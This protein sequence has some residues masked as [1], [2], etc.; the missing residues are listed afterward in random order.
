MK[1]ALISP[2]ESPIK[3]ITGWEEVEP[4][5]IPPTYNP[6]LTQITN[7][8]RVA[9]VVNEG[10]TFEIGKPLFWT[11]CNDDVV[12]DAYYYDMSTELIIITPEDIPYPE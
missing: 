7:S 1:K 2:N 10:Q 6:I 5:T 9:E 11:D 3:Y 12:A 4:T 8:C